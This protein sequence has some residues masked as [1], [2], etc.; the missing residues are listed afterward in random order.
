[1]ELTE[2][3]SQSIMVG[4]HGEDGLDAIKPDQV[5][6]HHGESFAVDLDSSLPLYHCL[7]LF[8]ACHFQTPNSFSHLFHDIPLCIQVFT[9]G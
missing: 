6:K 9:K 5:I 8:V 3:V 2:E 7:L 4:P 1:M